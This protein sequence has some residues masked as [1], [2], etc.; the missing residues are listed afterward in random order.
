ML[1]WEAVKDPIPSSSAKQDTEP[2]PG[3][4]TFRWGSVHT[5][6][7][8]LLDEVAEVLKARDEPVVTG[9]DDLR[10]FAKREIV[11]KIWTVPCLH[12]S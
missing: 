5:G 8:T 9:F 1:S 6:H 11:S 3:Q 10:H 12:S 4:Q 7:N 2:K